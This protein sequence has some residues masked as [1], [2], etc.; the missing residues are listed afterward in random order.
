M[1]EDVSVPPEGQ[2]L[3]ACPKGPFCLTGQASLGPW[4]LT[5]PGEHHDS[6]R[7]SGGSR[8]PG[9]PRNSFSTPGGAGASSSHEEEQAG[10]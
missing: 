9:L 3:A 10:H 5:S 7:K 8:K 6:S 1:Q 4:A 2:C